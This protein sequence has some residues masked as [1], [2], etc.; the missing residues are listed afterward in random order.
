MSILEEK[1]P[2]LYNLSAQYDNSAILPM[3]FKIKK[4]A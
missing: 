4:N 1:P 2:L 3:K